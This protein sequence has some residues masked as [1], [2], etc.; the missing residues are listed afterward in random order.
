[1]FSFILPPF[2]RGVLCLFFYMLIIIFFGF[3]GKLSLLKASF[4]AHDYGSMAVILFVGLM[5]IYMFARL[6][7]AQEPLT[8]EQ[9]EVLEKG[10]R[11]ARASAPQ[12]PDSE[13]RH[14]GSHDLADK[15]QNLLLLC[16]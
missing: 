7:Q 14:L 16:C 2:L 3:W 15:I 11:L 4:Q 12:T 6:W 8:A 5:T 13:P 9:Q 1:M 10:L